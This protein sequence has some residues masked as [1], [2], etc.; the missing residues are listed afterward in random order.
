MKDH[1]WLIESNWLSAKNRP[2]W[3]RLF[4]Y[5]QNGNQQ[6]PKPEWTEDANLALR[7]GRKCDAEWFALL[8][9]EMFCLAKITEH[10]FGIGETQ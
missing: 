5:V 10:V 2:M 6:A 1:G 9:P 4:G 7:F 3:A 8:Y